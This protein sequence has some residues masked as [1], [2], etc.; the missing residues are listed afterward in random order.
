MGVP[1][2]L[3]A[4]AKGRSIGLSLLLTTALAGVLV[5]T[6]MPGIAGTGQVGSCDTGLPGLDFL[7]SESAQ[8]NVLLFVPLSFLAVL[9]FRRP[10]LVLSATLALTCG[11]ELVQGWLGLGRACSYDD[12]KANFLGGV[13]GITL[14][15]LYVWGRQRKFP[16][17]RKRA[18]W[19]IGAVIAVAAVVTP[20]FHFTLTSVNYEELHHRAQAKFG[21]S[22]E[23]LEWLA[24]TAKDLY[25]A[26]AEL[27][28]TEVRMMQDGHWRLRA[29]T[30]RGTVVATWP[31]R[32]LVEVESADNHDDNGALS[33]AQMKES[34]ERFAQKWFAGDTKGAQAD[35]RPLRQ[36]RG[37]HILSYRRYSQNVM[38]PMRLDI[39]VTTAGRVTNAAARSVP[40]PALPTATVSNAAAKQRAEHEATGM[41]AEPVSLM[42]QRV[43]GSWRP[44]WLIGLKPKSDPGNPDKK[45]SIFLDAVTG[46]KV[47]PETLGDAGSSVSPSSS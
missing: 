14:G 39:I 31:D 42:A 43:G 6:M 23:K 13:I 44:V 20:L 18:A 9:F 1:A 19:G 4:K 46:K 45:S 30:N 17:T 12:V 2:A 22:T 15:C 38:M 24:K 11:I 7:A 25:G 47:T 27:G 8:L 26:Q 40:D 37:M 32:K 5:V 28:Q 33:T 16:F 36:N 3:I 21:D 10:L 41:Q 35:F 29:E 34:A